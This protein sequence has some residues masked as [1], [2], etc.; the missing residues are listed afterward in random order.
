MQ[1]H[2]RPLH[3][4]AT[5]MSADE[6]EESISSS[7]ASSSSFYLFVI[8]QFHKNMT[9]DNTRTGPTRLAMYSEQNMFLCRKESHVSMKDELTRLLRDLEKKIKMDEHSHANVR[10]LAHCMIV[11]I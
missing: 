1:G 2:L 8:R 9:A 11:Y 6:L 10:V 4:L 3:P 5:L 7:S